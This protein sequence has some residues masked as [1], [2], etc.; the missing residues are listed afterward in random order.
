VEL[1]LKYFPGLTGRQR[2]QF[3]ALGAL[4]AEWNARI[5]VISRR[6][7]EEFYLR[8]VL[9]SLAIARVC[10]FAD[11]AR[12]LDIGTGGGFPAIPLA[13]LFPSARFTAVDSI[14]KKIRVVEEVARGAGIEN[15]EAVNGRVEDVTGRFDYAVSRA[16]APAATLTGWVWDKIERGQAGSLPGGALFLKGG[17]LAAE[18]KVMGRPF[19]EYN[20]A[21]SFSEEFFETKKVVYIKK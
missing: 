4:Y 19:V 2:E 8:H 21:D 10:I 20:I 3:A 16:V 14:A 17:D 18:L 6:D 1:I 9:H 7:M 15:I 5:N 13:I 12:V 11:G